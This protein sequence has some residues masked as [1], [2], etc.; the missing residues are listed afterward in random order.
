MNAHQ[1]KEYVNILVQLAFKMGGYIRLMAKNAM[2][3]GIY[4]SDMQCHQVNPEIRDGLQHFINMLKNKGD[5]NKSIAN[6]AVA[7]VQI[8]HAV[9]N[10]LQKYQI[11]EDMLQFAESYE[12][13]G[14]AEMSIK[15]YQGIMNDFECDSVKSGSGVFTEISY[16]D[17]RPESEIEIFEKA[18]HSYERLTGQKVQEP[19]R[20]RMGDNTHN[21]S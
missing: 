2:D 5:E 21:F 1:L 16:I 12:N 11:G 13:I 14:Q 10:L 18:K 17:D 4:L 20:V 7:K 8:S 19:K 6:L 3:K 15:I 9:P